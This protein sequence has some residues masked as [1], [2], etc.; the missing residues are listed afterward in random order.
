MLQGFK[1]L[2]GSPEAEEAD[3][4]LMPDQ[5][6]TAQLKAPSLAMR[7]TDAPRARQITTEREVRNYEL[8]LRATVEKHSSK[9]HELRIKIREA[10]KQR[11]PLIPAERKILGEEYMIVRAQ[12]EKALANMIRFT[13]LKARIND[14]NETKHFSSMVTSLY[15]LSAKEFEQTGQNLEIAAENMEDWNEAAQEND[16]LFA[17]LGDHMD[18]TTQGMAD[19]NFVGGSSYDEMWQ[20]ICDECEDTVN[21]GPNGG[22]SVTTAPQT[23]SYPEPDYLS[24]STTSS[25]QHYTGTAMREAPAPVGNTP[26]QTPAAR[27]LLMQLSQP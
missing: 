16:D 20:Q 1:R 11:P 27:S 19:Q 25:G 9:F 15:S 12:Y 6:T 14:K 24:T 13:R 18:Q 26:A 7:V 10:N 5:M 4:H 3:S 8:T 2:L 23:V 17:R 21:N 22:G